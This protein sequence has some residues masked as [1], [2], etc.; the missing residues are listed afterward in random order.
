MAPETASITDVCHSRAA[1]GALV[2]RHVQVT[3]AAKRAR[4]PAGR[5][6]RNRARGRNARRGP[7]Y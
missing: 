2:V 3:P 7:S 5:A 4:Q 1:H 6:E